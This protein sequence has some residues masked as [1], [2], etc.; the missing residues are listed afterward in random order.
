LVILAP[1]LLNSPKYYNMN[2]IYRI[3]YQRYRSKWKLQNIYFST[4]FTW[5]FYLQFFYVLVIETQYI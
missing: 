3:L 2:H 5:I 4:W 1:D